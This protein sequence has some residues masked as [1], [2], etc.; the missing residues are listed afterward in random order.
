[1][2]IFSQKYSTKEACSEVAILSRLSHPHII[3]LLEFFSD[4]SYLYI[5][6]QYAPKGD[7]HNVT[8]I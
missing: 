6:M 1:M 7:L 3:K 2:I 4:E 5:V 8:E